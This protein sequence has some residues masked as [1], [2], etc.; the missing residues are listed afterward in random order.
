MKNEWITLTLHL[1]DERKV[2]PRHCTNT[3]NVKPS[4]EED[5]TYFQIRNYQWEAPEGAGSQDGQWYLKHV[6]K[7]QQPRTLYSLKTGF[8]IDCRT[9]VYL[10]RSQ[11]RE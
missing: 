6:G 9:Q 2:I 7:Q 10:E 4:G 11:Q 8:T 1:G 3:E 5:T